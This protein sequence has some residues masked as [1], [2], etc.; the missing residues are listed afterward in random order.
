MEISKEQ[1]SK[2]LDEAYKKA[3]HN[4]YFANGFEAGVIFA[5]KQFKILD[6]P[7]VSTRFIL[8][9]RCGCAAIRDTK[10]P[11]YNKDYQGLHHDTCDVVEYRH[12]F[13]NSENKCWEMRDEDIKFLTDY[14]AS[15]NG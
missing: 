10:H 12:G 9:I 1:I 4:A 13:Q 2:A 7:V 14:C 15:L 3:G 6:I 8:D 11:K 5:Q